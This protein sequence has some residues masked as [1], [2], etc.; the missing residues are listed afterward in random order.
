MLP[1]DLAR[2]GQLMLDSGN[3]KGKQLVPASWVR[4]CTSTARDDLPGLG[5]LWRQYPDHGSESPSWLDSEPIAP[6]ESPPAA[7][8]E[9]FGGKGWLGQYLAVYP[10]WRLVAVR[11]HGV[12]AGNDDRE[13]K[14][15]GFRSF[16]QRTLALVRAAERR[17]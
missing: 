2:I 11:L 17:R 1:R 7:V 10:R 12:E 13:D 14:I 4:A 15:Y 5:L 3:W 16:H 8:L 6:T 9:G